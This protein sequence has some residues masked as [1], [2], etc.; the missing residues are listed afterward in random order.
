LP[1]AKAFALDFIPVVEE[2]YDLLLSDSFCK[3]REAELLMEIIRDQD[4]RRQVESL[5][6]YSMREAGQTIEKP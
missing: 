2:R 1:A 3:S 4:F 6:G 5:G